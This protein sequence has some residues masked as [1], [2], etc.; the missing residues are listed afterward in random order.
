VAKTDYERTIDQFRSQ[1]TDVWNKRK[2]DQ[3]R[4]QIDDVRHNVDDLVRSYNRVMATA[5]DMMS[6]T[7]RRLAKQA[8]ESLEEA[9]EGMP[10]GG[11]S[12]WIP[13]AVIGAIGAGIWLYNTFM[14]GVPE[15]QRRPYTNQPAGSPPPMT[16]METP[17]PEQR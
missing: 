9:A 6:E 7:Q 10:E 4:S 15:A 5:T 1:L 13:V 2:I 8:R 16:S 3:L 17:F 14:T 12:W 11:F